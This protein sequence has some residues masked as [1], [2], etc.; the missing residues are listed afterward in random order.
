MAEEVKV[1]ALNEDVNTFIEKAGKQG[2]DKNGR[3]IC[4]HFVRRKRKAR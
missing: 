3:R 4:F 1:N 2:T